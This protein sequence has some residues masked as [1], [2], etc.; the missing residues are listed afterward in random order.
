MSS[1]PSLR[2][3]R[4]GRCRSF[5]PCWGPSPG[6]TG[7]REGRRT[8]W[9]R[10]HPWSPFYTET[11]QNGVG[12]LEITAGGRG[13]TSRVGINEQNSP[14]SCGFWVRVF[15]SLWEPRPTLACHYCHTC[16][17]S[18][19]W[20]N[21]APWS[22]QRPPHLV[23]YSTSWNFPQNN[24]LRFLRSK[25]QQLGPPEEVLP[26]RTFAYLY[27]RRA[28][29]N[30]SCRISAIPA[31]TPHLTS[32]QFRSTGARRTGE[33]KEASRRASHELIIAG[34]TSGYE[35]AIPEMIIKFLLSGSGKVTKHVAG[36]YLPRAPVTSIA[37]LIYR[38]FPA[39]SLE[40]ILDY[41][42]VLVK[43]LYLTLR[44]R[45]PLVFLSF[46]IHHI[47]VHYSHKC[48]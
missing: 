19:L 32:L 38:A 46:F 40:I 43:Y 41:L 18:C 17:P 23:K 7:R 30:R 15:L 2:W 25:Q 4:A 8:W 29:P 24:K 45:P 36:R 20:I 6:G 3:Q 37:V 21:T 44:D 9:R 16:S 31:D 48:C 34:D 26:V 47:I 13:T 10:T 1:S 28:R 35:T 42:Y 5:P 11:H 14:W 33:P 12:T 27:I 39:T 22:Q